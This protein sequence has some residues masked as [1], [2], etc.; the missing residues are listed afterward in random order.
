MNSDRI[1]GICLLLYI[2]VGVVTFGHA[3]AHAQ[4]A[5]DKIRADCVRTNSST[6]C[7]T[8]A[9]TAPPAIDGIGAALL[10]P[11]YWSWEAFSA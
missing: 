6:I 3:A 2:V 8:A 7:A 9:D 4:P 11:F 1:A 10:W 5:Y